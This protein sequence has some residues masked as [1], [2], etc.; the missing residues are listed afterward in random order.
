MLL[1]GLIA[2]AGVVFYVVTDKGTIEIRTDDENAKIMAVRNGWEV[3]ILDAW[4]NRSWVVDTGEW[5]V[6]LD[7]SPDGLR[8]EM[9]STFTLRRGERR[10]ITIKRMVGPPLSGKQ[11]AGKVDA[12]RAIRTDGLPI[13]AVAVSPDGRLIAAAGGSFNEGGIWK[14]GTDLD[15]RLY[16]RETGR[17]IRRLSGPEA[18][19]SCL[20][21]S[22]DGK[23]L[24]ANGMGDRKAYVWSTVS[25]RLVHTLAGHN[26]VVTWITYSPDGRRLLTTSWDS[27]LCLWDAES[28]KELR[29]LPGSPIRNFATAWQVATFL[30]GGTEVVAGG[31]GCLVI[32]DVE[33]GK[34]VRAFD[35]SEGRVSHL[36]VSPDGKRLLTAGADGTDGRVRLWNVA[37]GKLLRAYDNPPGAAIQIQNNPPRVAH[38]IAFLPDG[39]RFLT[40]GST[41]VRLSDVVTGEVLSTYQGHSDAVM[42]VTLVPGEPSAVSGGLDQTVRLWRLPEPNKP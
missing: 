39:R 26:D 6:R 25:G 3:T 5:T 35:W 28:G 33:T 32:L 9:P 14:D 37:T 7:G 16:D 11:A 19:V 31:W 18:A 30:P 13:K 15:V 27:T 24:A 8:L 36:S 17:E 40:A 21:F 12:V 1:A 4:G 2:A 41:T 20:T 22:P 38:Q 10:V 34:L 23:R 29:R 42:A